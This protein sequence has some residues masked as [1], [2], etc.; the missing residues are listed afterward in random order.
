[1]G[2]SGGVDVSRKAIKAL[3]TDL[4]E[5][6][7]ML[8]PTLK[9]GTPAPGMKPVLRADGEA[10]QVAQGKALA[11]FWPAATGFQTSTMNAVTTVSNSYN[12]INV[13][14]GNA[15]DLFTQVL[16]NLDAFETGGAGEPGQADV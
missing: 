7:G 10:Y 15:I 5:A 6:L 9:Q 3:R 14:V 2:D 13:Q 8:D 4:E 16:K 12:M 1:M 11:G